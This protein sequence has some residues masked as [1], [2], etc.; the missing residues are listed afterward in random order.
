[1]KTGINLLLL[2]CAL[3]VF[4]AP[5]GIKSSK[6]YKNIRKT[7]KENHKPPPRSTHSKRVLL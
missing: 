7:E 4:H 5:P 6:T 3:F 2:I 1:M